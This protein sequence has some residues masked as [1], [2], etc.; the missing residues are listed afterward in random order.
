[1][2]T[3]QY[4]VRVPTTVDKAMQKL[5]AQLDKLSKDRQNLEKQLQQAGMNKEQ[6]S[7]AAS[8]PDEL[9]KALDEMKNMS[10]GEKKEMMQ[11]ALA[12]MGACKACE[13][14]GEKMGQMGQGASGS[15]PEMRPASAPGAGFP[16][17]P[18]PGVQMPAPPG[19]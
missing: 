6:A 1:M 11:N 8:N 19:N 5:A 14:L 12:Q 7:K 3:V 2:K 9:K 13:G 4:T 16:G 17:G 15:A 10:E 18:P